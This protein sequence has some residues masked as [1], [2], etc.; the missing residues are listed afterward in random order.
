MKQRFNPLGY[1][2]FLG[3]KSPGLHF[4]HF[5]AL[6]FLRG[7]EEVGIQGRGWQTPFAG[8]AEP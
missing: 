7:I 3:F 1:L 5:L 8:R 4:L 2:G 6:L